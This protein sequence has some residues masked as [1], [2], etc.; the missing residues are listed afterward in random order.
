[1]LYCKVVGALLEEPTGN[2]VADSQR[3]GLVLAE[4]LTVAYEGTPAAPIV[5]ALVG[6][7]ITDD[8][9]TA[10]PGQPPVGGV[11]ILRPKSQ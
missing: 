9:A 10:N 8:F 4:A 6:D 11:I 7:L 3:L 5:D 2:P 1:M